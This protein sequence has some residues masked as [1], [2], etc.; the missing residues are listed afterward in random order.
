MRGQKGATVNHGCGGAANR[1]RWQHRKSHWS[2]TLS[3][4][5][6]TP[7]YSVWL[8][9]SDE[10]RPKRDWLSRVLQQAH[11]EVDREVDPTV[12]LESAPTC[13]AK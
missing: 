13:A 1:V 10:S 5:S 8:P 9:G 12:L 11:E 2:A 6:I 4:N 3:S 7:A